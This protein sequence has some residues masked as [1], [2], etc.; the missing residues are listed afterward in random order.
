MKPARGSTEGY[1]EGRTDEYWM[2]CKAGRI[3]VHFFRKEARDY[4]NLEALWAPI[5]SEYYDPSDRDR[6]V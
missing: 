5:G 3:V 2:V 4:Y 6:I 1:L